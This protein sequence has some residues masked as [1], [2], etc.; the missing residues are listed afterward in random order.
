MVCYYYVLLTS[1]QFLLYAPTSLSTNRLQV[2][3]FVAAQCVQA[4][5]YILLRMFF[6]GYNIKLFVF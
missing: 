4:K 6:L 3:V 2:L 5:V 1:S